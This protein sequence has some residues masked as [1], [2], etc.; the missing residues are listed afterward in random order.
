MKYA[1]WPVVPAIVISLLSSL[2]M[3]VD[4]IIPSDVETPA[5]GFVMGG[6]KSGVQDKTGGVPVA[7]KATNLADTVQAMDVAKLAEGLQN[8]YQLLFGTDSTDKLK[9][10]QNGTNATASTNSTLPIRGPAK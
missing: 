6:P 4:T 9:R 10:V 1:N 3:A 2:A 5:T 7:G 8:P